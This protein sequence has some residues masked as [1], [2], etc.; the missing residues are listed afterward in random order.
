MSVLR[1]LKVLY[2]GVDLARDLDH[3][4]KMGTNLKTPL[5]RIMKSKETIEGQVPEKIIAI[6]GAIAKAEEIPQTEVAELNIGATV[7][8][9]AA[10]KSREVIVGT[11]LTPMTPK[12]EKR[13][14]TTAKEA[15]NAIE[16]IA[17]TETNPTGRMMTTGKEAVRELGHPRLTIGAKLVGI[18]PEKPDASS[19]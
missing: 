19:T 2:L 16:A 3:I 13:K 14:I 18:D 10:M 1:L 5:T 7:R 6:T 17:K 9:E 15:M 4:P 11:D 8:T 12:E